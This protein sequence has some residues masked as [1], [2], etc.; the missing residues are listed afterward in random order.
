MKKLFIGA[1]LLSTLSLSAQ[2]ITIEKSYRL[3]NHLKGFHPTFNTDG[4]LLAFTSDVYEGLEVYNF[5]DKSVVKISD[6]KGAGFQP[7]FNED[8][9]VFYKYTTYQNRLR[10]DGLKSYDL[11]KKTSKEVLEPQRNL[12][13][14][15]RYGN[16]VMAVSEKKLLKASYGKTEETTPPY[17]W[18]DGSKLNIYRNGKAEILNPLENASGYIWASLSPNGTMILFNAVAVGSFVCD[19]NGNILASLGYLN[20]PAW[21]GDDFVVGMQDKDDGHI[22]TESKILIKSIDGKL[23]KQLSEE[24]QIAMY[25]GASAIAKKVAYATTDGDIY[26]VELK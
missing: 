25:P 15:Q 19:L 3:D 12:K 13:Q 18:S 8:G 4:S 16:G 23:T 5:S 6:E 24:G 22:I 10:Y 9:K 21:Y 26:I 7:V 2:T 1:L 14:M 11:T 17:V 20:A